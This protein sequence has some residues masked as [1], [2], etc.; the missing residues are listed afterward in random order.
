MYAAG[1]T[2]K[3]ENIEAFM[4]RFNEYVEQ[5]IDPN[6]LIPQVEIDSELLFSDITPS[7]RA[8]LEAFQPFEPAIRRPYS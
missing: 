3:P 2:M 4:H 6:M 1:L 8:T 7:F 5:N